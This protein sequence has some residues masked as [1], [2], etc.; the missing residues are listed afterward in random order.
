MGVAFA[1]GVLVMAAGAD[2]PGFRGC[3]AV[4]HDPSL[5]VRHGRS[6]AVVAE[7][8]VVARAAFRRLGTRFRAVRAEPAGLLVSRRFGFAVTALTLGGLVAA[9]AAPL[10]PGGLGTV[11]GAPASGMRHFEAAMAVVA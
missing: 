6:V 3:G 11:S 8:A 1:A 10:V 9:G 5:G 4:L 2:A 7:G